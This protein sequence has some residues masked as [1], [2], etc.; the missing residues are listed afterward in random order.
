[1][2]KCRCSVICLACRA[3]ISDTPFNTSLCLPSLPINSP[4]R[5]Q[6][7]GWMFSLCGE[8]EKKNLFHNG[9]VL[10]IVLNISTTCEP[11]SVDILAK[12]PK[13][14]PWQKNRTRS[15]TQFYSMG[16]FRKGEGRKTIAINQRYVDDVQIGVMGYCNTHIALWLIK[17]SQYCNELAVPAQVQWLA[18][19][20]PAMWPAL[21]P[22][23]SSSSCICWYSTNNCAI[24][25]HIW[26]TIVTNP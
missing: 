10:K 26:R 18:A 17:T 24:F 20:P 16:L 6:V 14:H 5:K 9:T 11:G 3:K 8:R 23:S 4:S 2:I 13:F 12:F 7:S 1:M 19:G 22:E 21:T 15:V 25:W